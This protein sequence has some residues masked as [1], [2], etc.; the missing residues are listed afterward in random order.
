MITD[1]GLIVKIRKVYNPRNGNTNIHE[2]FH[3]YLPVAFQDINNQNYITLVIKDEYLCIGSPSID[4]KKQYRVSKNIKKATY[5]ASIGS[6]WRD[7]VVGDYVFDEKDG[8][9]IYFTKL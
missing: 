9:N 2:R 3:L 6:K 7:S 1:E 4:S 8:D 5:G